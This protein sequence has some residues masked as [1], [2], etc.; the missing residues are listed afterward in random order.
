MQGYSDADGDALH[1]SDFN[2]SSGSF[3]YQEIYMG[4]PLP[5]APLEPTNTFDYSI[6]P[7]QDFN[8]TVEISVSYNG[9]TEDW[10]YLAFEPLVE[11][12]ANPILYFDFDYAK[13]PSK[14]WDHVFGLEASVNN[15]EYTT[16]TPS[17][18][19]HA[20]DLTSSANGNVNLSNAVALNIASSVDEVSVSYWQKAT[21]TP[22]TSSFWANPGR[23]IKEHNPWINCN[24]IW[25]FT[26]SSR[27]MARLS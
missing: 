20:M 23:A 21:E 5:G 14:A 27:G 19:G 22:D 3:E 11:G 10:S 24:I 2:I 17:G 25:R 13:N 9:L 6:T 4:L 26:F 7:E 12:G 16:D 15:A 1:I 18:S 8:G